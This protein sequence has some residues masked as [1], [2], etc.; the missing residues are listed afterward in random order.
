M[1]SNKVD[2]TR[3]SDALEPPTSTQGRLPSTRKR[4]WECLE[5]KWNGIQVG[6]QGAYSVERL[7]SFD[8]YCKTTSWT[9]VILVC[10]LTPIPALLTALLL[11]CL[12][13]QPPSE[14]WAANWVFWIRLTLATVIF[15]FV[16]M[17][18][19]VTLVPDLNPTFKRRQLVAWGASAAY[20]G[21]AVP[22]AIILGFP[23]PLMWYVGGFFVVIHFQ[24]M[25]LLVFGWKPFRIR[26]RNLQRFLSYHAAFMT[27]ANI[28]PLYKILY[29]FV[30]VRYRGIVA[31]LVLPM[32]RFLAR[33]FIVKLTRGLEDFMAQIVAMTIDLFSALF[34]SACMS[35]TTSTYLS[36][37]FIAADIGQSLLEVWDIHLYAKTVL[38][39]LRSSQHFNGELSKDSPFSTNACTSNLVAWIL[40]VTRDP[41][42]FHITS[43][44]DVRLRAC[45]PHPMS[46]EQEHTLQELEMSGVYS[47]I[48]SSQ[49]LHQLPR[50]IR[51]GVAPDFPTNCNQITKFT[52]KSAAT[53][54]K[55]NDAHFADQDST[56]DVRHCRASAKR[57]ESLVRQG[58]RLLFH[59]E[60]LTLVEY[61]ECVVPLIF[62]TFKSVL[63]H[64]PNAIYYPGG[65]DNWETGAVTNILV[66]AALEISSLLLL[67]FFLQRKFSFS[68]L[69][70]LAFTL[71]TQIY[72]V[73]AE[74]FIEILFL[75]QYE[76][77]HYGK[78]KNMLQI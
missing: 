28:Y 68:P 14:G 59:C 64:L 71:E 22:A 18:K 56:E 45:C 8:Y 20:V 33:Q 34:V 67:H 30:P 61:V 29:G 37:I 63:K 39:L 23:I 60:Y 9:R 19:L 24:A 73:Q 58:L 5:E 72:I 4:F 77:E 65:A 62:V 31:V 75:L 3:S 38:Q 50:A 55:I 25:L 53:D 35:T 6:H 44:K 46:E 13:L 42:A 12:P 52:A 57:S 27:L 54:R 76:L 47:D 1:R 70:Q 49:A 36:M 26:S 17:S 78:Q 7:E 16:G 43:L 66:F 15:G 41:H 51:V 21:T 69:Y 11:E 2:S 10:L 40:A 32:W 48:V 74:L